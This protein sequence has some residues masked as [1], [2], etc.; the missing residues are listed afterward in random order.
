MALTCAEAL[1]AR[2]SV[3]VPRP[4]IGKGFYLA[5]ED[6]DRASS[7]TCLSRLG[8]S[9]EVEEATCAREAAVMK[10]A[11]L[12]RNLAQRVQK[13][14]RKRKGTRFSMMES[15]ESNS[16][17]G[18]FADVRKN[19]AISSFPESDG[20]AR[21]RGGN[22]DGAV[23][24]VMKKARR[25]AEEHQSRPH[26]HAFSCESD[27]LRSDTSGGSSFGTKL[28]GLLQRHEAQMRDLKSRQKGELQLLLHS[29][30]KP[31]G[32]PRP[33][34]V[35]WRSPTPELPASSGSGLG[36]P[37]EDAGG[38]AVD[39]G[40][41]GPCPPASTPQPPPPPPASNT[42]KTPRRTG[43]GRGW[44]GY[45]KSSKAWWQV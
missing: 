26:R 17:L 9:P 23:A 41:G 8:P 36:F 16:S 33:R 19:L 27:T 28:E 18:G 22:E 11:G 32:G 3:V 5:E 29:V 15:R 34:E 25:A 1:R 39:Q 24:P 37:D 6:G 43:N 35:Q 7:L 38:L 30:S 45:E 42:R 13:L 40:A 14:K 44:H 21:G 20:E 12:V 2:A 10:P 4:P 31:D